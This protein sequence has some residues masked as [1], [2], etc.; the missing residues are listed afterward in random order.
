AQPDHRP[1]RPR[2]HPQLGPP[3]ARPSSD[4]TGR[5]HRTVD[6]GDV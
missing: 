1:P 5:H 3:Q 6:A 2:A 4:G